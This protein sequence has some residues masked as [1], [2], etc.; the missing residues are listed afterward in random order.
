MRLLCRSL[1]AAVAIGT[2]PRRRM[3]IKKKLLPLTGCSL[4]IKIIMETILCLILY[5]AFQRVTASGATLGSTPDRMRL[6]KILDV[7][8]KT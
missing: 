2:T 4:L 1:Q 5:S 3:G 6:T 8:A 7:C